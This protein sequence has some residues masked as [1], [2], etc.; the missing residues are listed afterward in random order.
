MASTLV[1][2]DMQ[3]DFI[4]GSLGTNDALAILQPV[5]EKILQRREDGWE[6][7]LTLDTHDNNYLQTQEGRKLPIKHCIKGTPGWELHPAIK[8][9]LKD[10]R[11]KAFEKPTFGSEALVAYLKKT[12]PDT[13]EFIGL[14]T[15][16]CVVSNAIATKM[17]LPEAEIIVDSSCCAGTSPANH[18]AALTT[19]AACQ[20]TITQDE[21]SPA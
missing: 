17:A 12:K 20:I 13:I 5:A 16:I 11:F 8:K 1:I 15:D 3:H 14:C 6:I 10:A 7:L 4:D 2:V 19:L 9:V 18:Q 21:W